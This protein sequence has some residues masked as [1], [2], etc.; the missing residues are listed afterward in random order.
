[1]KKNLLT[2]ALAVSSLL[3]N[4]QVTTFVGDGAKMFVSS[5]TLVYSGGNWVVNSAAEKTVENRGNIVIV[6]D[7]KKGSVANA[8][9]DGKEFLNVYTSANSYGQ[10]KI[11]NTAG[12]TDARMAIQRPAAST[13]YFGAIYGISFPYKDQVPYLMKSFGLTEADFEGSCPVGVS[14][15]GSRYK[16]TLEKWNNNKVMHDAVITNSNFTAGDYYS[17]N[18]RLQN[19]Q[20]AMTGIVAYKGTASPGAYQATGKSIIDGQTEASFSGLGYNDWKTKTNAYN[21]T[22]QSYLGYYNSTSQI[23]GKNVY[24]FGNPYTSNIDLSAIDGTNA[25]LHILNNNASRTIKDA[26]SGSNRLIKGFYITKRTSNYDLGW[27]PLSGSNYPNADYYKVVL[28]DN[29]AWQG[30]AEAL[31]IRP[32]ETFNLNFPMLDPTKLGN[33]R[34]VNVKVDFNDAHKTFA[35]TPIGPV[36]GVSGGKSAGREATVSNPDSFYQAE[37]FLVKQDAAIATPVYLVGSNYYNASSSASTNSNMIVVYGA[38]N[39]GNVAYDSKKDINEFNSIDYIGKPLGLGFNDLTTGETY[40]L[41]FNLYEGSI[42][43]KVKNISDGNF[44]LLDKSNDSVT[45][46]SAD[47]SYS[48]VASDYMDARFELYWKEVKSGT[49]GTVESDVKSSTYVYKDKGV[50]QNKI[51][52]EK[53]HSTA[54]VEVYDMAGKLVIE[55]KAVQTSNDF[56]VNMRN[57]RA[58]YVVKVT[59]DN[60]DVRTLKMIN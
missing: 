22:Y 3:A 58:V 42:F 28:D 18:L 46:V 57:G 55:E 43:N 33:T 5:G 25:W 59:Y 52:F 47:K 53:G 34:I 21:E 35:Y 4:A 16:M 14:C 2:L 50:D 30:S 15:G 32:F 38:T 7:Y 23:F 51:R 20:A 19:L 6:G 36:N 13:N 49:L 17:I 10:V 29:N 37:I 48:F 31:L 27:T 9:S 11:L 26:N 40:E 44:Y 60:G 39:N 56:A 12:G 41:R 54:K 45:E 24:R 1:M 8:A